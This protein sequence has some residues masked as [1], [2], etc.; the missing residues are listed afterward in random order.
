VDDDTSAAA[1]GPSQPAVNVATSAGSE[2]GAPAIAGRSPS[3]TS[4][5]QADSGLVA[6]RG[7]LLNPVAGAIESSTPPPAGDVGA[8]PPERA[9]SVGPPALF[10][11][12]AGACVVALLALGVFSELRRP[13]RRPRRT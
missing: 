3:S 7:L 5:L 6:V 13:G 9:G 4:A 12:G 2:R 10:G 11:L 1:P 8:A